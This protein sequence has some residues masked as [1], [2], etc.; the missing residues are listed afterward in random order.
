MMVITI[1]NVL[2][3]GILSKA[4]TS[5]RICNNLEREKVVRHISRISK[6]YKVLLRAEKTDD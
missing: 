6:N 5:R 2:N 4:I 1:G 3:D